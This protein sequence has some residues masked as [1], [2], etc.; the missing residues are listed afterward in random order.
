MADLNRLFEDLDRLDAPVSW[1]EVRRRRPGPPMGEPE[2]PKRIVTVVL[3]LAVGAA[4]ILLVLRGFV[5]APGQPAEPNPSPSPPRPAWVRHTDDAGVS[6][7]TPADWTFNGQPVPALAEP[8]MLFAVGTGPVPTGGDCAPQ[9]AIDSLPTDGALFTLTEYG[10]VD[11]PYTFPPRPDRFDLGPVMGPFECFG[12]KAHQFEFQD[13]GRFFQ[14]FAMFGPNAA[15]SLRQEVEQ[16]LDSLRVNPFSASAQPT[17]ACRG[18][19]WTSCPEAAW[20]YQV[21]NRAHVVHLGHGGVQA[22]L[23]VVGKRSFALWTTSSSAGLPS[24]QCRLVAGAKVCQIG[25]RLVWEAQGLLLWVEPALSPYSSLRT[26]P[27]LP[28]EPVLERLVRASESV[29][30]TQ[31]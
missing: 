9:P 8:A 2:R 17:A 19:R 4:G 18:G 28:T 11:E 21:I 24:G 30:L 23:G 31:P 26:N 10:S 13:G 20:V 1:P 16:S 22:I 27:G 5:F 7:D 14:V 25:T 12:V 29:V 6:I 15:P 3:A